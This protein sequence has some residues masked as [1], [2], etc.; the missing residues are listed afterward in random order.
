[1]KILVSGVERIVG[2]SKTGSP[3]DMCMLHALVPVENTAGG[4]VTIQGHGY[5]SM[6][7]ACDA[8]CLPSFVGLF[9]NGPRVI[10]VITDAR[11]NRG[12]METCVVGVT[13]VI[14]A[15]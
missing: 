6:D 7:I 11:P 10:D 12:K 15:A 4:K 13:A 2:T 9:Q 1:M 14:K 8:A 5:K 3:F